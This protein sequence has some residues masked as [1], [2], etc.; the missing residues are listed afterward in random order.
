MKKIKRM[1]EEQLNVFIVVFA[2]YSVNQIQKNL[3]FQ[4]FFVV[5]AEIRIF[6]FVYVKLVFGSEA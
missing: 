5:T 6:L 1:P 2:F 4:K 3:R